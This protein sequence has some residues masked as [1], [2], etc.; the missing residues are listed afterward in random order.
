MGIINKIRRKRW[1][2]VGRNQLKKQVRELAKN[3][4][5][6]KVV[7]GA[8]HITPAME[9]WI[10]TDLPQFDITNENHWKEIFGN[11]KVDNFLAEH[12][13]EH[14]TLEQNK[15]FFSLLKKH[16]KVNGIFRI[17]VPDGYH[18]SSEYINFVKPMGTGPGCEDHKMLWNVDLIN[19]FADEFGFELAKLEY[20]NKEGNFNTTD[21]SETNGYIYR[22]F[23]NCIA[24]KNVI[25]GYSSL[26]VDLTNK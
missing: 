14:L 19:S 9:G 16:L 4:S 26:I 7:L 1:E 2:I 13:L 24:N 8:S 11:N 5:S 17:A 23:K 25:S 3:K 20:Y 10:K 21:F 12:V 22:S 6:I 15:T 18:T